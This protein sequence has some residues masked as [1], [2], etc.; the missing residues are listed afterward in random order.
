MRSLPCDN[1]IA[2]KVDLNKALADKSQRILI[3]PGDVVML[4]YTVCEEIGN[5]LLN[6]LQFNYILGSGNRF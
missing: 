6:M 3:K 1:Q 2:I 5:L 4:R